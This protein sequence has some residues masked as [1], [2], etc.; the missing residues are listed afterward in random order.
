MSP[1]P[2]SHLIGPLPSHL[3]ISFLGAV[4]TF[5]R[6]RAANEISFLP[7][8]YTWVFL[9]PHATFVRHLPCYT[10]HL[11]TARTNFGEK[12]KR[13]ESEK[14]MYAW[15]PSNY[16]R[17]LHV[18]C[19]MSE[20]VPTYIYIISHTRIYHKCTRRTTYFS[21]NTSQM[22]VPCRSSRIHC[23]RILHVPCLSRSMHH[24]RILCTSLT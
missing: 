12:D 4:I 7:A 22:Y 8:M 24:I 20:A 17:I 15:V 5:G 18:S 21:E 6:G 14:C 19:V 1:F 16:I 2:S 13:S 23:I 9:T 10:G 3:F 11:G